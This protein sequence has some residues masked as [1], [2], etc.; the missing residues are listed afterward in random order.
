[1]SEAS[2][3]RDLLFRKL[4]GKPE[5][6]ICFDCPAKN[7]TWASVPYGV[8][9]CLACAGQHRSLGL[10][11]SF[12]RSTTL[13]TWTED[14][15]KLCALGGNQRARTF[16]K[17]HGWDLLGTDKIE[18][19]YTSRAAQLYK[20]QLDKDAAKFDLQ[21]FLGKKSDTAT[22]SSATPTTAAST[23]PTAG[24]SSP[25][26]NG[27]SAS[28]ASI[29]NGADVASVEG[30]PPSSTA[31]VTSS[32]GVKPVVPKP[33]A[34]KSRL[35]ASRKPTHKAGGLGI[36]KM[37]KQVDES[38]FEQAPEEPPPPPPVGVSE[39]KGAQAAMESKGSSRFAYDMLANE[40]DAVKAPTV[41]RGKDGHVQLDSDD[42][43]SNP[44]GSSSS[45]RAAG[46][47]GL[48]KGKQPADQSAAESDE[49]RRRFGNA[50]S[51]SSA[52]FNQDEA[53][54]SND[55]ERQARLSKFQGASA[56]SSADYYG[57]D[58]GSSK[59]VA[60]MDAGDLINKLSFQAKQDMQQLK[61]MAAGASKKFSSLAS[62]FIKDLQ[63]GY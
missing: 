20:Q 18:Q 63:G 59:G 33:P 25:A 10:H 9:I 5:N 36:K 3:D 2:P 7:P 29:D 35:A 22:S 62:N 16:F 55:Y 54:N 58:E 57:R 4:R 45:K 40:D 44:L 52:M 1:M 37:H 12:V 21:A 47:G 28:P 15:L 60:D 43:F 50:K 51:I 11:L 49:T 26:L 34:V 23:E 41:T 24:T 32:Q 46:S 39:P 56:I 17:Q 8:F 27:R 61:T 31:S 30:A 53:S 6:K 38:L 13:D 48:G 19:K 14:Q 42:F